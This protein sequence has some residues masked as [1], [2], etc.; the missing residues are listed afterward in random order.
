M[1]SIADVAVTA[2]K[3]E[4]VTT[5]PEVGPLDETAV[6]VSAD[7][8]VT[9]QTVCGVKSQEE[10]SVATITPVDGMAVDVVNFMLMVRLLVVW[11]L[12]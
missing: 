11:D 8:P 12:V 5:C 7:R 1:I 2:E 3:F 4:S 6:P 10:C 9:V